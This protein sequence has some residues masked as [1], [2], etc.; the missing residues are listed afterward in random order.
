[1]TVR[2]VKEANRE[3]LEVIAY[4]EDARR[5]L[6]RRFKEQVDRAILRAAAHP[7]LWYLR[8]GGYRRINLRRFPFYIPYIERG[9]I[10]WVLAVAH[11]RR[12]PHYW[13]TRRNEIL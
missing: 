8:P 7:Q 6:G 5:G 3:F 2:F 12:A 10:L 9:E 11:T 13:I 4:Y 1:V